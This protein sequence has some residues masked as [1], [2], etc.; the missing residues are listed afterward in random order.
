MRKGIFISEAILQLPDLTLLQKAVLALVEAFNEQGCYQSNRS[1]AEFLGSSITG[2]K[3]AIKVLKEKGYT[4]D[5]EPKKL[6]RCLKAIRSENALL[7]TDAIGRKTPQDRAE[8]DP[9][10]GGKRP[11]NR[12][13]SDHPSKRKGERK[14]KRKLK[15]TFAPDSEEL[16][17]AS[18]LFE[19]IRSRRPDF[20][21]SNLQAWAGVVNSMIRLD[22][23]EP[24][25]IEAV[26]RWC[27]SD[28]GDGGRWKGWQ[29]NVLSTATLREKFD[30]LELSMEG[31]R[32]HGTE[33]T[34]PTRDYDRQESSIGEVI[35]V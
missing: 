25:Q 35:N 2:V 13:E 6:K 30:K 33:H 11:I 1:L 31:A 22:K 32:N 15:E 16:R 8:F 19:C 9:E 26:I 34:N 29:N 4:E 12:A 10:Q 27:Q 28:T 3:D 14:S 5:I 17:L 20:K 21:Q 7:E 24:K 18:F 23:R